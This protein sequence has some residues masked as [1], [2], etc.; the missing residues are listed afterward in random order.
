MYK[1]LQRLGKQ[2]IELNMHFR[3]RKPEIINLQNKM[4]TFKTLF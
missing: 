4:Q 3:S 1:E 2:H